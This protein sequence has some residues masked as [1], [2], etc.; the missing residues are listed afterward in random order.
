MFLYINRPAEELAPETVDRLCRVQSTTDGFELAEQDALARGF[1]DLS[2]D[3]D[4][5]N[6]QM[7][8]LFHGLA[9]RPS[10]LVAREHRFAPWQIET[11]LRVGVG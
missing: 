11:D 3:G 9:L 8:W 1:G 7:P 2:N 4:E 10:D 5:Q 6:G